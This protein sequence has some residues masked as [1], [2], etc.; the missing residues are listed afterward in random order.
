MKNR[1]LIFAL[2]ALIILLIPLY[3]IL[4]SED[5]LENGNRH[6]IRLQGYD[7]FDPFRG[8]FL[9]LRYDDV[10]SCDENLEQGDRAFVLL[11]KDSLGY[12]YFASAES[13]KPTHNDYIEAELMWVDGGM[14]NIKIDNLTKYFINEDKAYEAER[15]VMD[16]TREKPDAIYVAIR[17]LNGEA[18]LED[19][20]V[21]E[22]PLLQ[23]LETH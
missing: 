3:V 21:E 17:V 9:R 4:N 14:A 16:F 12:S 5:V 19:I 15:V 1:K 22:T 20:F 7:P 10:I 18:R 8:K 2:F 6:K 13:E 23:Y 11:E